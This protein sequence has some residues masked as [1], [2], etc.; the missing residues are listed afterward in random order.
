MNKC[1]LSSKKS[2]NFLTLRH[3]TLFVIILIL[4]FLFMEERFR[5]YSVLHEELSEKLSFWIER[6]KS[7]LS[8][9]Y[10]GN[11]VKASI[12]NHIDSTKSSKL[13][14]PG[15]EREV[16]REKKIIDYGKILARLDVVRRLLESN[17]YQ[18]EPE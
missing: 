4:G 13:I 2:C 18:A 3:S 7:N 15:K 16:Y 12:N 1:D 5:D 10:G 14:L 9:I 17:N 8:R 11:K 6:A